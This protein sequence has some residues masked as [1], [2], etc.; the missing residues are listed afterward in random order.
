M[1]D[2][3]SVLSKLSVQ[4]QKDDIS[5]NEVPLWNRKIHYTVKPTREGGVYYQ[6]FCNRYSEPN[7]KLMCGKDNKQEVAL[8]CKGI[9]TIPSFQKL[10][11]GISSYLVKRFESLKTPP[12]S[13]FK[14]FDYSFWPMTRED[15]SHYGD[16]DVKAI[17]NH[18]AQLLSDEEKECILGEWLD[19]K[20][21]LSDQR[22]VKPYQQASG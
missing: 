9:N 16:D 21:L 19:L 22:A 1:I 20:L 15:L 17:A 14:V 3:T 8:T 2:V 11:N 12:V 10:L 6:A 18:F 5:I 7:S 13:C 4:F